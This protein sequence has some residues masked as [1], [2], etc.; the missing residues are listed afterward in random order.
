MRIK[1]A[2][3]KGAA[4]VEFAIVMPLL[5]LIVFGIIEFGLI[6]FNQQV[7]TNASREG[8]RAG[9]VSQ[10]PRLDADQVKAVVTKYCLNHLITFDGSHNHTPDPDTD[11]DA[12]V[13]AEPVF[14]RD[15]L[16]VTVR[17]NYQFLLLQA[18]GS[19][20]TGGWS[21]TGITLSATSVMKYE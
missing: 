17:W 21:D 1:F 10:D 2:S 7:I 9:I 18:I 8:A 3:Q 6:F 19:T 4:A 14:P 13:I 12:I 15:E 20:F 16:R 5:L 11:I